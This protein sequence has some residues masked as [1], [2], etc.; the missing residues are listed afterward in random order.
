M[1]INDILKDYSTYFVQVCIRLLVFTD[2]VRCTREG[3]NLTIVSLF[4]WGIL[5][6]PAAGGAG[7]CIYLSSHQGVFTFQLM[8]V[9][10]FHLM[11]GAYLG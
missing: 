2:L 10:T 4:T 7:G 6:L 5:N 11:G 9:P 3:N 8:G 1:N